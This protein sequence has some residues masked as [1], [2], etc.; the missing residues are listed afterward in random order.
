MSDGLPPPGSQVGTLDPGASPHGPLFWSGVVIGWAVI[1]FGAWGI[2]RDARETH[3]ANL[4]LWLAGSAL[5]DDLLI[6]P[7]VFMLARV[8]GRHVPPRP[9]PFLQAALILAA[10]VAVFAFPF[11]G[12]FSRVA[13]GNPSALPGN[14]LIGYLVVVGAGW[15]VIALLARRRLRS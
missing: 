10:L 11:I 4:G 8:L 9:R 14:Y 2:F 1:C 15:A 7:A 6:A 12:G 5:V 13:D 3:P